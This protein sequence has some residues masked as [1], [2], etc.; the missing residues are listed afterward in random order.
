MV[1]KDKKLLVNDVEKFVDGFVIVSLN[2]QV[3]VAINSHPP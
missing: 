3:S 1:K 2:T